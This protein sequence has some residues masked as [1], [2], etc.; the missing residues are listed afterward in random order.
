MAEELV[1]LEKFGRTLTENVRDRVFRK[2]TDILEGKYNTTEAK[3][4]HALVN[5][6][7]GFS[8]E[9]QEKLLLRTIDSTLHY[10]LWMIEQNEEFDLIV[11]KETEHPEKGFTS[12]KQIS[13]G[14]CGELHGED[15]WIEKFSE[16]PPSIK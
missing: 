2:I 12:L 10:I 6:G 11:Y 16:Y 13:D 14:L 5:E 1:K 7:V 3:E 4:L 15:G 8:S 9:F